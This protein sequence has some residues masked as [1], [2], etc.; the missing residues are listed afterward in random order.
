MRYLR[1]EI[2]HHVESALLQD[3]HW[4]TGWT[5]ERTTAIPRWTC[6]IG[7]ES[8]PCLL[9]QSAG[10]KMSDF[11]VLRHSMAYSTHNRFGYATDNQRWDTRASPPNQPAKFA[12][13]SQVKLRK[14]ASGY[15]K[16]TRS[17]ITGT[18]SVRGDI[19][20]ETGN[21]VWV[22]S[23]KIPE[24]AIT[25]KVDCIHEVDLKKL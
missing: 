25:Q 14:A 15:E 12:Q 9:A 11:N 6:Q 1:L 7:I 4:F 13:G 24:G 3:I 16:G 10:C 17:T 5:K 19:T 20:D 21:P 2:Y 18:P 23:M 8:D 22:Y